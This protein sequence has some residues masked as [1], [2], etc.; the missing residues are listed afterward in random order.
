MIRSL[1]G[2]TIRFQCCS[3]EKNPRLRE[4]IGNIRVAKVSCFLLSCIKT[5][6]HNKRFLINSC[7]LLKVK[8]VGNR[9]WF[10]ILPSL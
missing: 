8:V 10:I 5:Y 2:S 1:E 6:F 7:L 9:I 3:L 4:V